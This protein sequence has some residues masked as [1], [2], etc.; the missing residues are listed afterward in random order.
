VFKKRKKEKIERK[1][2]RNK[3]RNHEVT[4]TVLR[5]YVILFLELLQVRK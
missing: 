5:F 4:L 3:E 2:E 1:K